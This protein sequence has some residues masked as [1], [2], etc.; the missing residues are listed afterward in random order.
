MLTAA[1]ALTGGQAA[2]AA[3][4]NYRST[5]KPLNFLHTPLGELYGSNV[6]SMAEMEKRLPKDVFKSLK[7]TIEKGAIGKS[8]LVGSVNGGGPLLKLRTSGG[9]INVRAE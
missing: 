5:E 8:R 6:F 1:T 7:R 3:I 4:T 2:I 9:D